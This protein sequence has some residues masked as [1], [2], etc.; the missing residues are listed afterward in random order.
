MYI[1]DKLKLNPKETGIT[2]SGNIDNRSDLYQI[3]KKFIKPVLFEKYN[4]Y[5][6]YSYTFNNI[7]PHAFNSLLNLY[8]CE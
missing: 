7:L 1:Y 8:L 3:L 5:F 2:L 4:E 6:S